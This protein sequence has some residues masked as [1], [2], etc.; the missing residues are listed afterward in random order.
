MGDLVKNFGCG[1]DNSAELPG[2]RF[3]FT[4]GQGSPPSHKP[5]P[6]IC[7][8]LAELQ[9]I[10]GPAVNVPAMLAVLPQDVAAWVLAQPV[11]DRAALRVSLRVAAGLQP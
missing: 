2:V 4:I 10:A 8:T 1:A 11:A 3:R 6:P 7:S 5:S 9:A